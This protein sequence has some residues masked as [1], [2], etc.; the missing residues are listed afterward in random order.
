[1]LFQAPALMRF[2]VCLAVH[3]CHDTHPCACANL[4]LH[5]YA[6]QQCPVFTVPL[7]HLHA[8]QH[9]CRVTTSSGLKSLSRDPWHVLIFISFSEKYKIPGCKAV[10][11]GS[12]PLPLCSDQQSESSLESSL[13][14]SNITHAIHQKNPVGLPLK[15]I[16]FHPFFT[17]SIMTT[18]HHGLGYHHPSAGLLQNLISL[19]LP[20]PYPSLF[21]TQQ[22]MCPFYNSSWI[23]SLL[24]SEPFNSCLCH[25]E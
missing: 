18:D 1:M 5:P 20:L 12:F 13:S 14:F 25:L 6:R 3:T 15:Y 16:Q 9:L 23:M 17:L 11:R 8:H 19:T 22:Q 21:C 7:L 10:P 24:H 4:R 2:W